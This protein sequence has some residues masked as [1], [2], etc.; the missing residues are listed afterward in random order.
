MKIKKGLVIGKFLPPHKGHNYLIEFGLKNCTELTVVVCHLDGQ[1]IHGEIRA[2]WLREIHPTAKVIVVN[3]IQKDDDSLAWANYTKEF[4]GYTP[5]VVFTSED[6]G[7]TFC[8]HLK[9]K[10]VMVD[11]ARITVPISGTKVRENPLKQWDFIHHCVRAHY[12]KR[13]CIIG[14]EST[15]T[16]TLAKELAQYY[17]TNWVPE[18]GR[19]YSEGKLATGEYNWTSD[20]FEHIAEIQNL[21]ENKLARSCNKIL[22]CDTDSFATHVWHNRYMNFYSDKVKA[23][24]EGRNY[25]LYIVTL[26]DIPFVQDGTRDGEHIRNEMHLEFIKQLKKENKHFIIVKGKHWQRFKKAIRHCDKLLA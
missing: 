2:T 7:K 8:H 11:K 16:T 22:F 18:Y 17:K 5:D 23:H 3:D 26:N 4:L 1:P 12:A 6:Y 10:H 24:S 13:V 14:A 20:E 19:I 21:T 25:D 15:G 9:C